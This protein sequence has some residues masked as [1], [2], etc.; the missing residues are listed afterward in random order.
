MSKLKIKNG[1]TWEEIPAGG[2]G[3]PSGGTAGQVLMKSSA[4]DYATQWD[5]YFPTI[6]EDVWDTTQGGSAYYETTATFTVVG[7]GFVIAQDNSWNDQSSTSDYGSNDSIISY[8]GTVVAVAS[9]RTTSGT[10]ERQGSFV[11]YPANVSNGDIFVMTERH[12]K[13]GTKHARRRF[14]CWGC[15]ITKNA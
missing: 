6:V 9:V 10:T 12:T 3:V 15:T 7:N 11:E 5:N 8:N 14:L 2:V 4:T 1:N 13:A